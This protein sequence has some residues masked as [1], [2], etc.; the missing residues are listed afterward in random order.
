MIVKI[1][2]ILD[3]ILEDRLYIDVN[4]II[5]EVIVSS[6]TLK[7]LARIGEKIQLRIKHI[8]REDGQ[9]LY[10]FASEEEKHWF[11]ELTKVTGLGPK[12]AINLLSALTP[13]DI[14]LAIAAKDENTLTIA[15]GIGK[16]LASRIVMELGSNI[17]KIPIPAN[18]K[19]EIGGT[20]SARA[21]GGR[22]SENLDNRLEDAVNALVALGFQKSAVYQ[23]VLG[24]LT[25]N[26]GISIDE[27][28]KQTLGSMALV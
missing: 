6:T 4:G 22:T 17:D 23:V 7:N 24:K 14:Y 10:G 1:S 26:P 13:R 12:F 15:N 11:T 27:L 2:G 9:I 18:G 8:T 25:E 3:E 19:M 21:G 28:I 16:K 5:Y 20:K